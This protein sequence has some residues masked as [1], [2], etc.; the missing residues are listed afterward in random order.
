MKDFT[1]EELRTVIKA[2]EFY[3]YEMK[4]RSNSMEEYRAWLSTMKKFN[5]RLEFHRGV[6]SWKELEE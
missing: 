5:E 2:L 6:W 4:K 1:S 3:K